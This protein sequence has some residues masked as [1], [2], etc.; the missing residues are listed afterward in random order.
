M[1]Y[2][3]GKRFRFS[4]AHQLWGLPEGHKCRR[5]HGHDY[6]V[7]WVLSA[8]GLTDLGMVL[9]Y[10]D[11]SLTI[12]GLIKRELD[13]RC[14]GCDQGR[15][16]A[17]EYHLR[18][19]GQ[20]GHRDGYGEAELHPTAEVL[21]GWLWDRAQRAADRSKDY[22]D[23]SHSEVAVAEALAWAAVCD[24]TVAVIVRETPDTFARLQV[25]P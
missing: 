25:W 24:S 6:E 5:V 10:G 7:E 4:A 2:T 14:L 16:D 19:G 20:Q 3:I 11:L 9:D 12:G 1:K 22:A 8:S 21:A 18:T 17:A 13:H 15:C 23:S